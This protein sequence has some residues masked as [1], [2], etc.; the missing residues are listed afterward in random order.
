MVHPLLLRW[1]RK[2]VNVQRRIPPVPRS[3]SRADY[4]EDLPSWLDAVGKQFKA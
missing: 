4:F 2:L 3:E 1:I